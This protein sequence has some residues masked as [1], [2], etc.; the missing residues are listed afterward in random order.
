MQVADEEATSERSATTRC[1][2]WRAPPWLIARR[3]RRRDRIRSEVSVPLSTSGV[4][5]M[6]FCTISVVYD[7]SVVWAAKFQN[8]LRELEAARR[9]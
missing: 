9:G 3:T 7:R 1:S 4:V 6:S 8:A 5:G 2:S